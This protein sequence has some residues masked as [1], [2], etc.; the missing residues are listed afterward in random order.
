M[1]SS[2]NRDT[3]TELRAKWFGTTHWSVVLTA[4]QVPSANSEAAL[5]KL[6]RV[7]WRPLYAYLR[8]RGYSFH[9]SQDLTQ[10]FLARLLRRNDLGS[11]NRER[12]KFRSYLLAALNNF[13]ANERDR[14]TAAK[15]GGGQDLVFWDEQDAQAAHSHEAEP[16]LSPEKVYEKRWAITVLEQA[17]VR[18][19][20]E[21][22]AAGK[23]RLFEEFKVFLADGTDNGAYPVLAAKVGMTPNAVAV[24]V[25]RLRQRYREIVRAEVAHTVGNRDQIDE[26]VRHLLAALA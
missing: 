16:N 24:A 14:A 25:H 7:Y 22:A 13:L 23:S 19:Q 17:F 9:D 8:R 1:S 2:D 3:S 6:C 11:V 18:L 10:E 20:D 12:G 15:R 4:G 5:E 26:E 21:F